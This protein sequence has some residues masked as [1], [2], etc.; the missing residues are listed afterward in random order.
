MAKH[1]RD[2][3]PGQAEEL[4]AAN[5]HTCCVCRA[6]R[7]HVVIHH[8]D[9]DPSNNDWDNLAVVCHD[10]HSRVTG[11]EGLGRRFT[12]GE[13]TTY[14]KEWEATCAGEQRDADDDEPDETEYEV[15]TVA[16]DTH[17]SY[18]Y[19]LE[20]GDL[21]TARVESD[22]PVDALFCRISSYRRWVREEAELSFL[23]GGEGV[24]EREISCDA[25]RE[26]RYVLVIVNN[27]DGDDAVVRVDI[28]I[29][30]AD[31]DADES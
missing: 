14:K 28:A 12:A 17:K 22:V 26:G 27:E 4:M 23:D 10:C 3:P 21:F 13:V 7:K 31:E 15:T 16:P 5:R 8:I 20:E 25:D 9:E 24:Y 6:P 1:R 29:W 11:D 2:V 18:E 30:P 19:D